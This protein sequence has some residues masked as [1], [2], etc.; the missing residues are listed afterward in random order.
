MK[1]NTKIIAIILVAL[2][3]ISIYFMYKS[4]INKEIK[5][6][7]VKIKEDVDYNRF[8][9]YLD[10]EKYTEESFP[11]ESL[12]DLEKT[13]CMN[14]KGDII[15]N[16]KI[17][18]TSNSLTIV[19]TE[20]TY[21]TLYFNKCKGAVGTVLDGKSDVTNCPVGGMY[22]YQGTDN[23]NNW[24]CFGTTDKEECKSESGLD[25]YMYRII[26]VTPEGELALIK[27]TS[28][29]EDDTITFQWNDK[30]LT[31]DCGDDG[32]K[33][34]W[35]DSA[36]FKRLNGISNGNIK[37]YNG[38]T[39]IFI[40]NS[41]Y[42]YLN[43]ESVW[44]DIITEHEWKYGDTTSEAEYNGNQMYLIENKFT[45]NTKG[46]IGLMY[47]HDYLL[48]YPNGNPENMKIA[49]TSWI[50]FKKDNLNSNNYEWFITR[51]GINNDNLEARGAY[52][53]GQIPVY[54]DDTLNHS[55]FGV[56][57]VFYLKNDTTFRSGAGSKEDPYIIKMPEPAIV[58][59]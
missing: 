4:S 54:A 11:T 57:P 28:V 13:K 6:D 42:D 8:A 38:N 24:I 56:R 31:S 51:T 25:K 48:A 5:L 3:I 2:E 29:K 27:E 49:K 18:Y 1:K 58:T 45:T 34:T 12:L 59:Q 52:A 15:E 14:E 19:N 36:I 40:N 26:G 55:S 35:T 44:L 41:Y 10:G 23:V 37:G 21:C 53:D 7:N 32:S 43:E 47:I 50:H 20:T 22:R 33:C 46:K 17:T 30:Y 16:P 9:I 39:N